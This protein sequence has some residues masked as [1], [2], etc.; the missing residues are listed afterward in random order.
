MDLTDTMTTPEETQNEQAGSSDNETGAGKKRTRQPKAKAKT[1]TAGP[2]YALLFPN[3]KYREFP[4]EELEGWAASVIANPSIRL[5]KLKI[6]TP[7]IGFAEETAT[8]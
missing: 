1:A 4:L 8:D 5:V 2:G 7:H 3:G 6:L